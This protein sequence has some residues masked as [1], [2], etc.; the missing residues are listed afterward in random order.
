MTRDM[1]RRTLLKLLGAAGLS[2]LAGPLL[3][4]V[5]A[6]GEDAG[7]SGG[8]LL[9][10]VLINV[11]DMGYGDLGCYGGGAIKTPNIDALAEDGMRFT[12]FYACSPVCSPSR[13]GLLTGRYPIRIGLHAA[14]FPTNMPL[15]NSMTLR[16][17]ET[18]G[19]MDLL[20]MKGRGTAVGIP[21]EEITIAEL[22]KGRGYKTGMVGKWHLGDETPYLPTDNGFDS[23]FGV[24][25]SNDMTPFPLYRDDEIIEENIT[26]QSTLTKRYTEAAL[27][28]IDENRDTP[29]FFYF[30]HTFPHIPLFASEDFRGTSDGGL[31]GDTVEELD[32]SV[33]E[34]M[35]KLDELNLSENTIVLFTSDN[36][37]WYEGSPGD[38]RGGKGTS[39]EGGF[40][41]PLIVRWPGVVSP[42]SECDEVASNMDLFPTLAAACGVPVPDDRVID[43]RDIT[44]LLTDT[45]PSPHEAL[46]FYHYDEV[47]GIRSGDWK[48]MRKLHVYDW[49][50]NIQKKGPW[51]FNMKTDP[52]ERY[53]L[54]ETHPDI[55]E[56]LEGMISDWEKK[57]ALE[58]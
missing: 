22:L 28:F 24:P 53:D 1:T 55:A 9:N 46:Y 2:S 12:D 32:W 37:S 50:S 52:Q 10:I 30:A 48:Y 8:R 18:L 42:G 27:S 31:Y 47:Q 45:G 41:V 17:H 51:L 23:F 57:T 49:P 11:D 44:E 54:T 29:F 13:F 15:K 4:G 39:Y 20:D 16:F 33:G 38:F 26:D 7:G 56:K 14:L 5:S 6:F 43:G 21:T 36:G 3:G 25:Y 58:L 34:V 19:G 35:K 40:R